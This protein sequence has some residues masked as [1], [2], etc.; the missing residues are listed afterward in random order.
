MND[1]RPA[2]GVGMTLRNL[3]RAPFPWFGGKSKA[4]DTVWSLLGDV[5]H[6]VEPFFGSG[7][8]LLGRPHPANRSTPGG[9]PTHGGHERGSARSTTANG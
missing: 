6:Y 7:A 3:D 5:P 8:V 2:V 1:E 9:Q 4:A